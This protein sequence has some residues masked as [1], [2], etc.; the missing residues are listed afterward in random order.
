M[1]FFDAVDN[2]FGAGTALGAIEG[3]EQKQYE[4]GEKEREKTKQFQAQ[5]KAASVGMGE[6]VSKRKAF[7]EEVT[8]FAAALENDPSLKNKLKDLGPDGIRKLAR[9]ALNTR[10]AEGGASGSSFRTKDLVE[11]VRKTPLD[12]LE[13]FK[14]DP[15]TPVDTQ[16]EDK[17][18]DSTRSGGLFGNFANLLSPT[19]AGEQQRSVMRQEFAKAF[20]GATKEELDNAINSY[21]RNSGSTNEFET[22]TPFSVGVPLG[23]GENE[24]FA[25]Q[26]QSVL[27]ELTNNTRDSK[28]RKIPPEAAD[29]RLKTEEI[30]NL[31]LQQKYYSV[32]DNRQQNADITEL[33]MAFYNNNNLLSVYNIKD[34]RGLLDDGKFNVTEYLKSLKERINNSPPATTGSTPRPPGLVNTETPLT[35]GSS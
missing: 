14:V 19:R 7:N 4:I 28:S 13:Q 31:L 11:Q 26:A 33:F 9:S 2:A 8:T 18:K 34:I 22:D 5:I 15:N 29:A 16:K 23:I 12:A 6:V 3:F 21:G 1:G 35:P 24:Q 25:K 17:K 30:S 32:G 10:Y 27:Q 20:P